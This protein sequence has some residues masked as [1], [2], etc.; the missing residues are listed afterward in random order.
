VTNA[1]RFPGA[2]PGGVDH[3]LTLVIPAR[4]EEH[5]LSRTLETVKDFL[6]HWGI[7]YR[8]LVVDNASRDNT[9]RMT[10]GLGEAFL[11]IA[12]PQ[13]GKGAAVRQGMLRATGA[14][15]AF[16]DAD[17]PYDLQALR[18][19]YDWIQRGECAVVFGA[20]DLA[21]ASMAVPR[22][23]LRS[24]ASSV[25]RE[26]ARRRVSPDVTDTQCGF[27]MFSHQAAQLVFS[28]AS[29]DG[30]AFDAEVVWLARRL[31]LPHAR[32]PVSL[33]NDAGSTV[34][35]WR[36]AWPMFRDVLRLHWRASRTQGDA[37]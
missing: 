31:A 29:V 14:V 23:W 24:L 32:V 1:D 4:N 9:A 10:R 21:Q 18:R 8:V 5:R 30:F 25:F 6:D 35:L 33:I 7:D 19:G 12:Q 22:R 15:V 28:R 37:S 11:T 36:D 3:E 20:R 34:V 17:L 2:Q 27:K 16:T 26:I 13:E